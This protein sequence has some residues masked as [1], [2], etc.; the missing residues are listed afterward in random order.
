MGEQ[1]E[2]SPPQRQNFKIVLNESRH[3]QWKQMVIGSFLTC[4]PHCTS[5]PPAALSEWLISPTM[6]RYTRNNY[7]LN[8]ISRSI[9]QVRWKK[10]R[11]E[12]SSIFSRRFLELCI[13]TTTL[14]P[15]W[16]C[17]GHVEKETTNT[18]NITSPPP[19]YILSPPSLPLTLGP[20]WKQNWVQ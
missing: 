6:S 9:K 12:R 17:K 11:P 18:L 15:R 1:K 2:E 5:S 13:Q 20:V 14:R 8:E 4:A 10:K 19:F 16:Q 7:F 3:I